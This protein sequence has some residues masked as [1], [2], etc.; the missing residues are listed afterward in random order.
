MT[1]QDAESAILARERSALDLWSRGDPSG[2]LRIQ[3][4][5]VTYY[6][7]IAAHARVDGIQAM[8]DYWSSLRGQIPPHRY[9]IEDPKVQVYGDVGILTLTYHARDFEGQPLAE[10]KATSVYQKREEEWRIVHAHWSLNK[11]T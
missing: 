1:S 3:S 6:D 8:R 4:D 10:W 5:D 11:G 7:D 2:Y 9:E